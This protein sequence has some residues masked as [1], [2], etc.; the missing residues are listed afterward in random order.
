VLPLDA[1]R[2]WYRYHHLLQACLS[3]ELAR[4]GPTPTSDLHRRAAAWYLA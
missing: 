2:G 3:A 4:E 1:G